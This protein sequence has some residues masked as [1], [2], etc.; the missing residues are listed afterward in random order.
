MKRFRLFAIFLCLWPI[1]TYA[2]NAD[3]SG[4]V[5]DS[6]GAAIPKV[7]VEFRNQDTGIRQ[8][9]TTNESGYYHIPAIQPGKYD[10]TVQAKSFQ[11]LT[12]EDILLQ[13]DTA[14]RIDFTLKVGASKEI[15]VVTAN[16]LLQQNDDQMETHISEGEYEN[17]PLLRARPGKS[18]LSPSFAVC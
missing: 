15:V 10:A 9:A 4:V 17:L 14:K 5:Q 3:V 7:S 18:I 12:Q 8:Q 6:S 2:Q 13:T 11:T 1:A 16:G